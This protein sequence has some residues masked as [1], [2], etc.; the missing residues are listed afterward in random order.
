VQRISS[1][2]E[3]AKKL[4]NL[5]LRIDHQLSRAHLTNGTWRRNVRGRRGSCVHVSALAIWWFSERV[6][7]RNTHRSVHLEYAFRTFTLA[8]EL[9][10][11]TRVLFPSL[12]G[13]SSSG[14]RKVRAVFF[15]SC[16]PPSRCRR[17]PRRR[18]RRRRRRGVHTYR[19]RRAVLQRR[20][21]MCHRR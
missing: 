16:W 7:N 12:L 15:R 9:L 3:E 11:R 14:G 1:S 20:V 8:T 6:E 19:T 5:D 17:C 2:S 4:N 21:R 10:G 18:P 13:A